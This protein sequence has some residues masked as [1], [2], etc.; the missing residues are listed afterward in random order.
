MRTSRTLRR[1][2]PLAFAAIVAAAC[3]SSSSGGAPSGGSSS[4]TS[5]GSGSTFTIAYEGPLSGGNA[6][7][8]E[9]MS[10][11]VKLAV[12]QAN[13]GTTFGK[14]P[15]KLAF[16]QQD[17]QGSATIAPTAAQKILGTSN[18]IAVVGPA[19]SGAT[20]AA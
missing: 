19:Y 13:A 4:S 6:Q 12:Q 16:T 11:A 20:A 7:L 8:G 2:A 18:L 10:Y 9:N 3:G 1:V 5:T 17:D 14:L 15:F